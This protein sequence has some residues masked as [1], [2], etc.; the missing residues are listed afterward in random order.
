LW[1]RKGGLEIKSS[2]FISDE[3][4]CLPVSLWAVLFSRSRHVQSNM[5]CAV[6]QLEHCKYWNHHSGWSSP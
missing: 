4:G 3:A 2:S 1:R 6:L 5:V